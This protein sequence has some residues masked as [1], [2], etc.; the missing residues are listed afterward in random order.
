MADLAALEVVSSE[1]GLGGT[2]RSANDLVELQID[3]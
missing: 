2:S 1:L 3:Q